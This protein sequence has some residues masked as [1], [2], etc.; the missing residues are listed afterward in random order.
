MTRRCACIPPGGAK[1]SFSG[2][3]AV[4]ATVVLA[5]ASGV[6]FAQQEQ[7]PPFT[8]LQVEHPSGVAV[9]PGGDLLLLSTP[10]PGVQAIPASAVL[11]RVDSTGQV[12]ASVSPH[13][14]QSPG[15]QPFSPDEF[16]GARI[17]VAAGT[18]LGAVLSQRGRLVA[19]DATDS[20]TITL[21]EQGDLSVLA[22]TTH[23][24]VFDVATGAASALTIGGTPTFGD[25]AISV[26]TEVTPPRIDLFVTATTGTGDTA[27]TVERAFVVRLRGSADA[28]SEVEPPVVV[29]MSGAPA[30]GGPPGPGGTP[31]PTPRYGIAT[32]RSNAQTPTAEPAPRFVYV[33]LPGAPRSQNPGEPPSGD[34]DALAFFGADF[35]E[36][37]SSPPQFMGTSDGAPFVVSS[38]GMGSGSSGTMFLIATATGPIPGCGNGAI[39]FQGIDAQGGGRFD[40]FAAPASQDPTQPSA[41]LDDA[42]VDDVNGVLYLTSYDGNLLLRATLPPPGAPGGPQQPSPIPPGQPSPVPPTQPLPVPPSQP[43]PVSTPPQSPEPPAY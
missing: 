12:V 33:S 26:A 29:A 34:R 13:T 27:E 9:L 16:V 22:N 10:S 37:P 25:I 21:G 20:S 24:S 23:P 43:P 42:A 7:P 31:P 36:D 30:F 11:Q 5:I 4:A 3:V 41:A 8:A 1:R 38:R 19:F 40:C 17:D 15:A 32:A 35:P 18:S 2:H 6:A 28:T 14:A 39:L